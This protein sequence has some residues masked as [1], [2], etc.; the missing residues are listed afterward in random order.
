MWSKIENVKNRLVNFWSVASAQWGALRNLLPAWPII[1]FV[2]IAVFAVALWTAD[3]A[4]SGRT[5][6]QVSDLTIQVAELQKSYDA[7]RTALQATDKRLGA[8]GASALAE[9]HN[10][11]AANAA[12]I[13]AVAA[14][15]ARLEAHLKRKR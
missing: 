7:L 3:R 15:V 2:A 13:R 1:V 12:D 14:S 9:I 5:R 11:A 10:T 8:S 4:A 6:E